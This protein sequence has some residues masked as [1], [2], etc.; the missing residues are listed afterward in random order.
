MVKIYS[1]IKNNGNNHL[2]AAGSQK[3]L[4]VLTLAFAESSKGI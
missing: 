2:Q 3:V 1:T 4:H